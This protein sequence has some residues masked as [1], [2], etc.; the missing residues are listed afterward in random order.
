MAKIESLGRSLHG[1]E[2]PLLT[3]GN[4]KSNRVIVVSSRVHPG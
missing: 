3:V 4:P 1:I 2:M